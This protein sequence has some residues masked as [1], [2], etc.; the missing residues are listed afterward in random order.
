M[1]SLQYK[2]L[3]GN[4][5]S[6]ALPINPDDTIDYAKL[7]EEIGVLV[8][9]G[10][11]G[12]YTNG[13]AGEFY[14]QNEEEFDR[15]NSL[16]ASYC[17]KANLPFQLG[18]SHMSAQISL[19]RIKRARTFQPGAIQVILADWFPLTPEEAVACL[20]RMAEVADPIGL[21]LYNPPHAKRVLQ[22]EEYSRLKEAVPNL[23]GIKVAD[24]DSAWYEAM[25]RHC[26]GL[27][28]FVPGHHLATGFTHGAAGSYS[29]VACLHPVGAQ[30]WY[31][32]MKNDIAQALDVEKR[33]QQFMNTHILP[34][35]TQQKYSNQALDKLLAAIGGWANIGTRLRWP[36]RWIP[37][38]E[39]ERLRPIA[40][41]MI[42]ELFPT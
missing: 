13:T 26:E 11:D 5:A 23:I 12:I 24:S 19:E 1:K 7:E 15:I 37:E 33:I 42:P 31:D 22:P 18:A 41:E 9:A 2:E 39:A 25:K 14:A 30:M 28:I 3:Q 35:I 20:T 38:K 16:V 40:R 36:Y 34:F 10:V 6:I 8:T 32:M 29:N 21:V 4:W 27:A 17:E